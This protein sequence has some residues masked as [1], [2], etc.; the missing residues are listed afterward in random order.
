MVIPL[1]IQRLYHAEYQYTYLRQQCACVACVVREYANAFLCHSPNAKDKF[2][3]FLNRHSHFCG[4]I[5]LHEHFQSQVHQV[6]GCKGERIA[7]HRL[8]QLSNASAQ[9]GRETK[10]VRDKQ[11]TARELEDVEVEERSA[12]RQENHDD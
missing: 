8:Q 2:L 9:N 11:E 6:V 10:C 1:L 7:V 5:L 3:Q 4:K 12:K